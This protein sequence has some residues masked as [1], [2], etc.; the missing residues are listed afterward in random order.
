MG[1]DPSGQ[2]ADGNAGTIVWSDDLVSAERRE[3]DMWY[4]SSQ[5]FLSSGPQVSIWVSVSGNKPVRA[6]LNDVEL[7]K[8]GP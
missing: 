6:S 2:T 1:Y 5:R 7:E 3:S 8:T 4:T